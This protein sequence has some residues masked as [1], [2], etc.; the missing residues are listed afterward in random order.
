MLPRPNACSGSLNGAHSHRTLDT[1]RL[2]LL[3]VSIASLPCYA[4]HTLASRLPT[5]TFQPLGGFEQLPP[6]LEIAAAFSVYVADKGGS[7]SEANNF[8]EKKI[9]TR[10][11][12]SCGVLVF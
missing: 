7:F 3:H 1:A 4:L 2:F 5:P 10:R 11:A 12:I 6:P 9:Q 8:N